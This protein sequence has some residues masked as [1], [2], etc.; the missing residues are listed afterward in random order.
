MALAPDGGAHAGIGDF[1]VHL[2]QTELLRDPA[3]PRP[4]LG[5]LGRGAAPQPEERVGALRG[6][7]LHVLHHAGSTGRQDEAV[8]PEDADHH[9]NQGDK[10][11]D[12]QGR[13]PV[14]RVDEGQSKAFKD[15]RPSEQHDHRLGLRQSHPEESVMHM[16]L[17]GSKYGDP[18]EEASNHGESEVEDREPEG[19][20]RRNNAEEGVGLLGAVDGGEG[21]QEAEGEAAGIPEEDGGGG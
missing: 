20:H 2:L 9:D 8:V 6:R 16:V 1:Q 17:V 19:H 4:Q 10:G 13:Q 12:G 5:E 15:Q 3:H 14:V 21:Q 7:G 18:A 11:R